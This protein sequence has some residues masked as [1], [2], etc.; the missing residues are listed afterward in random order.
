MKKSI[1]RTVF[2]MAAMILPLWGRA[3]GDNTLKEEPV[4]VEEISVGTGMQ[5]QKRQDDKKAKRDDRRRNDRQDD[6]RPDKSS[7]KKPEIKEVPRSIPK[8]KPKSVTDR[9]K[10]K[11][12]P[13]KVKPKGLF[14]VI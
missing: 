3:A 13:V 12:P 9:V 8:L 2:F 7:G 4:T 1:R 5:D 11:R 6:K 14:R 10:I